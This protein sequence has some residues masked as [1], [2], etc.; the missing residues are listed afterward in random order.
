DGGGPMGPA[1]FAYVANVANNEIRVF[2]VNA[3]TG[4]LTPAANPIVGLGSQPGQIM[5][6]P[7]NQFLLVTN[8]SLG[9]LVSYRI[10]TATGNF[11]TAGAAGV[12]MNPV[13]LAIHPGGH[14]VYVANLG[15][16]NVSQVNLDPSTGGVTFVG[17]TMVG[18][19]PPWVTMDSMGNN[20]YVL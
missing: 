7:S 20:L 2:S 13:S 12:G 11:S 16:S 5:V 1:R 4:D 3:Q 6:D 10:D 19:S 17:N 15:S 8:N 18:T 14:F 9:Q